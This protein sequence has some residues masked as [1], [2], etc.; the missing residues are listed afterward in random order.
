MQSWHKVALIGAT[1]CEANDRIVQLLAS[2]LWTLHSLSLTIPGLG[3]V[4]GDPNKHV[5]IDVQMRRLSSQQEIQVRGRGFVS[6]GGEY[7][8]IQRVPLN[9]TAPGVPA[10]DNTVTGGINRP[11]FDARGAASFRFDGKQAGQ[12]YA[13]QTNAQGE[14]AVES[15]LNQLIELCNSDTIHTKYFTV[16]SR[17]NV[18]M[19]LDLESREM[20]AGELTG[21]DVNN[22]YSIANSP[23]VYRNIIDRNNA[24]LPGNT[25]WGE[26]AT[27]AISRFGL[28][29]GTAFDRNMSDYSFPN[30]IRG[31]TI[32]AGASGY[33]R[34]TNA[35]MMEYENLVQSQNELLGLV[36]KWAETGLGV[37]TMGGVEFD[38]YRKGII[39]DGD[40]G[41]I[42]GNR[43]AAL[44][45]AEYNYAGD[46]CGP[47]YAKLFYTAD[48]SSDPKAKRAEQWISD[49]MGGRVPNPLAKVG[50][51]A[52]T[53]GT[54][55]PLTRAGEQNVYTDM[56]YPVVHRMAAA[57][58][59]AK[60]KAPAKRKPRK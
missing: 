45:Y 21:A 22:Q 33:G 29:S 8:T 3:I 2:G 9:M 30:V 59:R 31:I 48:P 38:D 49:G 53:I 60:R 25:A 26:Q 50:V 58:K 35:G 14:F 36:S 15:I 4:H 19:P 40:W 13:Y 51:C 7:Y 17:I 12:L 20:E 55:M 6:I 11:G 16:Q 56:E 34:S 41:N 24:L 27:G 46:T 39:G 28:R 57:Q 32:S 1:R 23:S 18:F 43:P 47:G 37:L 44:K 54:Q 10:V 5:E 52:P 42:L